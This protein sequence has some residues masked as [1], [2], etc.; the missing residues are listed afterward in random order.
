MGRA[1]ANENFALQHVPSTTESQDTRKH[2]H[3][4]RVSIYK[5]L[6]SIIATHCNTLQ[7]YTLP[8]QQLKLNAH[9]VTVQ[10]A[11]SC[12][13]TIFLFACQLTLFFSRYALFCVKAALF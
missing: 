12:F 6:Y 4:I 10:P 1:N 13:V 11:E 2:N 7:H 8:L 5:E 3:V 9:A